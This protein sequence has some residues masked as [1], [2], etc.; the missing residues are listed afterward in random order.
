MKLGC[1][2]LPIILGLAVSA[3]TTPPSGLPLL[4]G[5][6]TRIAPGCSGIRHSRR[7]DQI[8][9]TLARAEK[10]AAW[11]KHLAET[12]EQ[13]KIEANTNE[14]GNY[15]ERLGRIADNVRSSKMFSRGAT[16]AGAEQHIRD[17]EHNPDRL[18]EQINLAHQVWDDIRTPY[19]DVSLKAEN[20][21]RLMHNLPEKRPTIYHFSCAYLA[22]ITANAVRIE[23]NKGTSLE[24]SR[25]SVASLNPAFKAYMLDMVAIGYLH[26]AISMSEFYQIGIDR[27]VANPAISE[28]RS[29]S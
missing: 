20:E 7:E 2:V 15:C 5:A 25:N 17:N 22:R 10:K 9:C 19:Q 16:L 8:A 12:A 28:K 13:R 18:T 24:R 21:C 29:S 27:C 14:Q 1:L 11:Q 6:P 23:M 3:C 26:P 4:S